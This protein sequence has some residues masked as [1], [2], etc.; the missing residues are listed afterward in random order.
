[1]MNRGT[2]QSYAERV[3]SYYNVTLG[4]FFSLC[5]LV[6]VFLFVLFSMNAISNFAS[7]WSPVKAYNPPLPDV[8]NELFNVTTYDLAY[9]SVVNGMLY[10]FIGVTI[11]FILINKLALFIGMKTILALTISYFLRCTTIP[12]TGLPDSWQ[13]GVRSVEDFYSAFDTERGGDL[14]FSG[15]TLLV[16]TFAHC[17]SSFYLLTNY[18]ALHVLTAI[19]AWVYVGTLLLFI[20]VGRLHYTIDILLGIYVASGVWWSLSYFAQRF[21]EEPVC[22]FRFKQQNARMDSSVLN[23][24]PAPVG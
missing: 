10:S 13:R 21:F 7:F 16:C 23:T 11:F 9:N 22:R 19:V 5:A 18:M 17:W 14:V 12:M 3:V 2:A 1:M 24:E 20:I 4:S 6:I 8:G 15:H